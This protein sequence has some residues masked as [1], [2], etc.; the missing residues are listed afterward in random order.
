MVSRDQAWDK[1]NQLVGNGNLVKHCLAV[2]A[3]MRAYADYFKLSP[4]EKERWGVAGLIHDADWE[5]HSREHPAIVL[6]WLKEQGAREDVINAVA[7][8]SFH[9]GPEAETLMAKTLRAVDELT[10]LIVAV[11]LV[12][13][14]KK[15]ADVSVDSVLKKWKDKAFARGVNRE[16]IERGAAEIDVDLHDHIRI[17]LH[18]MRAISDQLGL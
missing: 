18:A 6:G 3:G 17:V 9:F 13:R 7:A 12:R 15:L 14:S 2:E 8:H 1:L 11:A 10:G 16:D 5:K 4:E